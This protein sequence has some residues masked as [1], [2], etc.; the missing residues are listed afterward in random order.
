MVQDRQILTLFTTAICNLKCRYCYIDKNPA[1]KK[2]DDILDE[3][4][5]GDYYYNFARK[6]FPDINQLKEMQFWGGEPSIRLDR[7]KYTVSK[8]IETYPNLSKFMMSTNF[9]LD[10]FND[11]LFGFLEVLGNYPEREFLFDLQL[12]IDGPEWLND[13]SRGKGVT[14]RFIAS[15]KKLISEVPQRLPRNVTLIWHFKPTLDSFSI[16]LLQTKEKIIEYF[17]FFDKFYDYMEKNNRNTNFRYNM[18]VPNTACPS[19]HTKED[20]LLFANYCKL[21]REIERENEFNHYF[22]YQKWITSFVPR[23]N[24]IYNVISYTQPGFMCGSGKF[25]VGLLPYDKISVCH[26]GF[27]DIIS[28][29]KS[30]S[31]KSVNE[32]KNNSALEFKLFLENNKSRMCMNYE[33]FCKYEEQIELFFTDNPQERLANISSLIRALARVHQVDEKYQDAKEAL[34]GAIF[35]ENA[36]SYCVRDNIGTTGSLYLYPVGLLKL[37]LNGAREYIEGTN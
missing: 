10:E 25:M 33:D 32:G 20:G 35:I 36:T 37:L 13:Y 2:I 31:L 28:D 22:K 6:M 18:S 11:Q 12:S 8:L 17:Q 19:P 26:N 1:L 30:L 4:F 14:K 16:P 5:K 29:Y 21:T 15:F 23:N 24:N 9:T 3:S 7:A 34:K 27:V